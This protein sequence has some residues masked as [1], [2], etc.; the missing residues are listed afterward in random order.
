VH[1]SWVLPLSGVAIP[2]QTVV[3]TIR[4]S[5]DHALRHWELY[6]TLQFLVSRAQYSRSCPQPQRRTNRAGVGVIMTT[7]MPPSKPTR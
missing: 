4:E 2:G 7:T 5:V 6:E 1:L 3:A